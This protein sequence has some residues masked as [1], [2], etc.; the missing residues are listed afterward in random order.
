MPKHTGG[1]AIAPETR[2]KLLRR[3]GVGDRITVLIGSRSH[4]LKQLGF[5]HKLGSYWRVLS[6]ERIWP[7]LCFDNIVYGI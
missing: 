1:M 7:D 4:K 6:R 5:Y 3:V 2:D